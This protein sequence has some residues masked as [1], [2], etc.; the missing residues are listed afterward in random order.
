MDVFYFIILLAAH[1]MHFIMVILTQ[2]T[3]LLHFTGL[4]RF[5]P[6]SLGPDP[7]VGFIL[8]RYTG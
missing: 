7:T 5:N 6:V 1:S 4:D 3:L 8:L 2:G